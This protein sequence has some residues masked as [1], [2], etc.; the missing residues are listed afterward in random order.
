MPMA[1]NSYNREVGG[2]YKEWCHT[3]AQLL[4]NVGE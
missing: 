2:R 3:P 4:L 1:H